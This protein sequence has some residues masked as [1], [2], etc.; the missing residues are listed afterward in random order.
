MSRLHR[1]ADTIVGADGTAT[2]TLGPAGTWTGWKVQR[3]S[4]RL[5]AGGG[6]AATYRNAINEASLID[7]TSRGDSDVAD[8]IE[9]IVLPPGETI[10][11]RW[12]GADPGARATAV[13]AGA[14]VRL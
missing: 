9:P 8:Y 5:S 4:V 13:L 11:V 7:A 14:E 10:V 2:V 6:F 3:V 12:S 1:A